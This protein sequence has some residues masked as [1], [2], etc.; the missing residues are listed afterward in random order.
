MPA[1]PSATLL[2]RIDWGLLLLFLAL[3]Y[4]L[5]TRPPIGMIGLSSVEDDFYYY[6]LVARHILAGDGSTF[7]GLVATNGYHPLWLLVMVVVQLFV[8]TLTGIIQTTYILIAVAV[9]CTYRAARGIF[10]YF[11]SN[12][13]CFSSNR[14]IADCSALLVAI[15]A[16]GYFR[17][18]MEIILALPL[19]LFLLLS[20]LRSADPPP[21]MGLCGQ[22]FLASMMVL[23]RLDA[24]LLVLL[25]VLFL[26]FDPACRRGLTLR[27]AIALLAGSAPLILYV[28]INLALFGTVMPVSGQAKQLRIGHHPSAAV[29]T[30][31]WLDTCQRMPLVVALLGLAWLLLMHR[32]LPSRMR[33]ILFA[34][35]LFPLLQFGLLS[36]LSDW[37]SWMWYYYSFVIASCAALAVLFGDKTS[38]R[39]M[40]RA[41]VAVPLLS[42][43]IVLSAIS[44]NHNFLRRA[45]GKPYDSVSAAAFLQTFAATHPGI[46]AIGD[47][48]GIAAVSINDPVV[49][50]EGL[51]MD[52]NFIGHIRRRENLLSVLRSYGVRYYVGVIY[53]FHP[54]Y[55][56]KQV[57]GCFL[58]SE[59]VLA[60]PASPRMQAKICAPPVAAAQFSRSRVLIFDLAQLPESPSVNPSMS[61]AASQSK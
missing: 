16:A 23:A 13:L 20:L 31:T 36:M 59:P 22:A 50:T 44:L 29:F 15:W 21:P 8:H 25:L 12:R 54:P 34:A 30:W 55:E 24:A 6:V 27:H 37:P 45:D 14:W 49:Q 7:N 51:I 57:D 56:L 58:A 39:L 3:V 2:K 41:A 28:F 46:Y 43:A 5:L 33:A 32:R 19:A 4:L 11:S 1:W 47:R 38:L 60:G 18:G 9:L 35:V 10:L 40:N 42:V 17:T 26:A 53:A 61:A 52:K 48:S